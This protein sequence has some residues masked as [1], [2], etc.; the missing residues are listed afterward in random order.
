M[1]KAKV[2]I[3]QTDSTKTKKAKKLASERQ[4]VQKQSFDQGA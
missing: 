2:D 1:A 4:T 3:R